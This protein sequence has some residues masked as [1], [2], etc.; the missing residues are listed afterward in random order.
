MDFSSFSFRTFY[1][2]LILDLLTIRNILRNYR[3]DA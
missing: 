3:H 1:Y 2:R